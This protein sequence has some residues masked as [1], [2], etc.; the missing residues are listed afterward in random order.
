MR[1]ILFT[2]ISQPVLRLSQSQSYRE[3]NHKGYACA[4]CSKRRGDSTASWSLSQR[5][6]LCK[7]SFCP[8]RPPGASWRILAQNG[9]SHKH[10]RPERPA[11][12]RRPTVIIR[13]S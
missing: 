10:T 3:R 9:R 1:I 7:R 13:T 2:L 8:G 6:P 12:P 5:E 4:E 11:H